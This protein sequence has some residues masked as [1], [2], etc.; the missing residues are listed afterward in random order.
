LKKIKLKKQ[1]QKLNKIL[2]KKEVTRKEVKREE[3]ITMVELLKLQS[4]RRLKRLL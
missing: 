4:K 2:N 1:S 3:R